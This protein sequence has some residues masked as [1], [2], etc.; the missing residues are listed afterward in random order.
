MVDALNTLRSDNNKKLEIK[1]EDIIPKS[2]FASDDAR[3]E[4]NKV[5]KTE[6]NV[7]R[8]K[9]IYDAGKYMYDFRIFDAIRPFGEDIY[10]GKIML[11]EADKDQSDLADEI[12]GFIKTTKPRNSE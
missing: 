2:V 7:D 4:I 8:E 1:N 3:E 5:L 11:R 6:K 9:L 10:N 12:N